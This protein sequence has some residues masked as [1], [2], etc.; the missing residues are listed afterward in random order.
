MRGRGQHP[1]GYDSRLNIIYKHFRIQSKLKDREVTN[2]IQA[3]S[4]ILTDLEL[5][6][7]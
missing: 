6:T 5:F 2:V 7:E 3:Q 1:W 4:N